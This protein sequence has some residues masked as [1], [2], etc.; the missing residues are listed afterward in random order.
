MRKT[1]SI[2][3]ALI[4]TL[5]FSTAALAQDEPDTTYEFEDHDVEGGYDS[6]VGEAIIVRQGAGRTSLIQARAHFV[7]ELLKSIETI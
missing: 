5:T 3:G 6:P 4:F 7:P 1:L 2:L